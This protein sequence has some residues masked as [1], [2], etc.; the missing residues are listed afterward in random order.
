MRRVVVQVEHG[1]GVD[2]L[3]ELAAMGPYRLQSIRLTD[4]HKIYV[5]QSHRSSPG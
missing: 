4:T 2:Y 5:L 1:D 3:A